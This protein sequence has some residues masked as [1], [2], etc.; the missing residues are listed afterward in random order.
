MFLVYPLGTL[1]SA[2]AGRLADRYGR[3]SVMPFGVMGGQYQAV[4]HAHLVHRM[5][6][7]GLDPQQAAEAPRGS[8]TEQPSISTLPEQRGGCVV[9]VVVPGGSVVVVPVPSWHG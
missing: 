2:L 3:R 5:V 1:S 7:R 6:D 4:G 9:V 8:T